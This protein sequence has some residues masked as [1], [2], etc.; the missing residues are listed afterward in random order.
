[1]TIVRRSSSKREQYKS[2]APKQD[3]SVAEGASEGTDG[4]LDVRRFNPSAASHESE[5]LAGDYSLSEY[6]LP[7]EMQSTTTSGDEL[8]D[9]DLA[10][11]NLPAV[12]TP[13]ACDKAALRYVK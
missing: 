4:V 3:T 8:D 5:P 2:K 1:M 6:P 9:V 10:T 7:A 11:D 13:D 12:D